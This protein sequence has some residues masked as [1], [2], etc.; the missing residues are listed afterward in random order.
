MHCD[1]LTILIRG[2]EE[3]VGETKVKSHPF[4]FNIRA[5]SYQPLELWQCR[6][7]LP[8]HCAGAFPRDTRRCCRTEEGALGR[9]SGNVIA[10]SQEEATGGMELLLGISRCYLTATRC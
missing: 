10:L 2:K 4:F 5:D 8:R 7:A 9:A 3:C 6:A 1:Y